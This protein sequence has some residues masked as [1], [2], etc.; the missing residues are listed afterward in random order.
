MRM[1]AVWMLMVGLT[2]CSDPKKSDGSGSTSGGN[3]GQPSAAAG[4][5][6]GADTSAGGAAGAPM[7]VVCNELPLDAPPYALTYDDGAVPESTGGEIADGTYFITS[8]V[9]YTDATLPSVDLGRTAV[10]ISGDTW[11]EVSGDPEPDGVNPDQHTTST[12]STSGTTLTLARSCPDS[13]PAEA[14]DYS[15]TKDGF[16]VYAMDRGDTFA[17]VFSRQ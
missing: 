16:I 9:L 6:P 17:T 11:Q 3:A 2:A 1:A 14:L 4:D 7:A 13:G 15:V 5:G 10:V 12:L 8:Q